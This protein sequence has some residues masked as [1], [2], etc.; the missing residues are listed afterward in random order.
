MIKYLGDPQL[1]A[2]P[3]EPVGDLRNPNW[4]W[5]EMWRVLNVYNTLLSMNAADGNGN[6]FAVTEYLDSLDSGSLGKALFPTSVKD[7]LKKNEK[8]IVEKSPTNPWVGHPSNKDPLAPF[9]GIQITSGEDM[10]FGQECPVGPFSIEASFIL[11]TQ[12][13]GINWKTL[14][15]K[16]NK[17]VKLTGVYWTVAIV[18]YENKDNVIVER[19]REDDYF[20]R[21]FGYLSRRGLPV[22][23]SPDAGFMLV[24]RSAFCNHACFT[25]F[26]CRNPDS[27]GH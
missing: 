19:R 14:N 18:P 6:G 26:D 23:G 21:A 9:K 3:K 5:A 27:A 10:K 24:V 12:L 25:Q 1:K 15:S 7:L 8:I 4:R 2:D 17:N 11:A 20:D 16:M 13:A 22:T